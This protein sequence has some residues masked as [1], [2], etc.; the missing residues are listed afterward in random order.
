MSIFVNKVVEVFVSGR[1]R[2]SMKASVS[3]EA[4]VMALLNLIWHRSV[5]P[6][7]YRCSISLIFA[8]Y[9][10]WGNIPIQD[11]LFNSATFL[12]HYSIYL[13]IKQRIK[14]HPFFNFFHSVKNFEKK[15]N[16]TDFP[17]GEVQNICGFITHLKPKK[18]R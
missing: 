15:K 2:W 7:Q 3:Q 10:N 13:Q 18:Y 1:Q 11:V 4:A 17:D 5:Q 12:P 6:L 16:A 9:F 8:I 14:I